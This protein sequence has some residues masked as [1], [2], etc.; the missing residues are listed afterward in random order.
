M[1]NISPEYKA[2]LEQ[3]HRDKPDFGTSSP[4]YADFIRGIIQRHQPEGLLDFG[5]GKQA[6][7]GALG[8]KEGYFAYDPAI[9][10]IAATPAPQDL[11]VCSDVLEHVELGHVDGVIKE[12]KR[13]TK[14][15]GFFVIHTGPALNVL[16]DGRNAHITQQKPSWWL[17][18]LCLHFEI[19]AMEADKYGFWVIVTPKETHVN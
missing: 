15:V 4:M 11:C 10:E 2:Q 5:A 16:P 14:K 13:V 8:I 6:L 1:S 7:K 17:L 12:L 18:K 9:P 19:Q 3:L